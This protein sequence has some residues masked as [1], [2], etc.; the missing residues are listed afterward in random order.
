MP[1]KPKKTQTK[2]KATKKPAKKKFNTAELFNLDDKDDDDESEVELDSLGLLFVH[3]INNDYYQDDVEASHANDDE[4]TILSFGSEP[5]PT[6]KT[7]QASRK[8]RF[9]H[10]LAYLDPN[11]LLKKQQH[12]L[13]RTTQNSGGG[14][15]SPAYRTHPLPESAGTRCHKLH[16]FLFQKWVLF[17]NH[18]TRPTQIIGEYLTPHL[19][20]PLEL[21]FL[22][23]ILFLGKNT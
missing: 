23:S 7:R 14:N 21:R 1:K 19:V 18:L 10:P 12:K 13:H 17:V 8:V 2:T 9:S 16:P 20:T 4:V 15:I 6:Q 22:C 5:L 11:F 3:L